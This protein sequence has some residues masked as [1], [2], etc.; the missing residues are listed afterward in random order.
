MLTLFVINF[1]SDLL[2]KTG[3]SRIV[4]VSSVAHQNS[5]AVVDPNNPNPLKDNPTRKFHFQMYAMSKFA[6][7][8]CA[9]EMFRRL[10]STG[11]YV[12]FFPRDARSC[13]IAWDNFCAIPF[14]LSTK[15]YISRASGSKDF[16]GYLG[17]VS[18]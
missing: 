5:N 10:Q 15:F 12:K 6:V 7:V 11:A 14:N 2:K 16:C 9:K 17:K 4:I 3:K 8:L 1:I 13:S 18:F